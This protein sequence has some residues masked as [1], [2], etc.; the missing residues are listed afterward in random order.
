[1]YLIVVSGIG[2]GSKASYYVRHYFF[3][4]VTNLWVFDYSIFRRE[5]FRF[6]NYDDALRLAM[7]L[8]RLDRNRR[9]CFEIYGLRSSRS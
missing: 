7:Q 9:Y 4:P 5:A 3:G 1:M 2:I 8:R 6:D